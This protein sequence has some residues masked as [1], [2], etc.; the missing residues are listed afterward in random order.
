ME[1]PDQ[2]DVVFARVSTD[3]QVREGCSL[4]QQVA[5][6]SNAAARV[7]RHL[8]AAYVDPG[9]SATR[10]TFERRAGVRSLLE[11][12]RGRKI[13]TIYA[14]KRD[15]ISR[16]AIEWSIFLKTCATFGANIVFT[17]PEEPPIGQGAYGQFAEMIIIA[18]AELEA[19]ITRMRVR[20]S[21]ANRFQN[22]E[23]I[24]GALP[25]GLC[26]GEDGKILP[27]P[28]EAPVVQEIFRLAK[29]ELLGDMRIADR[30]ND[31]FPG[32][33][34]GG[35]WNRVQVMRVLR[36]RTYCGYLS[37]EM[38]V[39]REGQRKL[40]CL[41][42]FCDKLP[43][44]VTEDDWKAVSEMRKSR[45]HSRGTSAR[46]HRASPSLLLGLIRCGQCGRSMLARTVV[47][48][49]RRR[50]G[51]LS[52]KLVRYY[53]CPNGMMV[54]GCSYWGYAS[55]TAV[56]EV[57]WGALISQL[58]FLGVNEIL[59]MATEYEGHRS[60]EMRAKIVA[61]RKEMSQTETA[62]RRNQVCLERATDQRESDYYQARIRELVSQHDS[63]AQ[64]LSELEA[65][66]RN[67]T[68]ILTKEVVREALT[69]LPSIFA[70][71]PRE[72]M[73]AMLVDAVDKVVW[74]PEQKTV[75]VVFRLQPPSGD[76]CAE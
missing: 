73:R 57:V 40:E 61:A 46:R 11:D 20:D 41:E 29:E 47:Q 63:Q 10:L 22:G 23:W 43:I 7:G 69:R 45:T 54:R 66:L 5:F 49:Y 67:R 37:L 26:R 72:R 3:D 62:L 16:T 68:P 70:D 12:V 42:R 51:S 17:C 1:P 64:R 58:S 31:Q 75:D 44:L 52:E 32:S 60:K 33:R 55:Q 8:I 35:R 27:D 74:N 28:V 39:E 15:R 48:R 59:R 30:L 34:R 71:C 36:N 14:Y 4:L 56:E 19:S 18:A 50:D 65:L 38:E 13:R 76:F 2:W 6:A 21:I 25:Y 53:F 24:G 9:K